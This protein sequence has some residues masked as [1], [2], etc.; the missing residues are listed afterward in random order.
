MDLSIINS[1]GTVLDKST[2]SDPSDI[3]GS[4]V[5]GNRYGWFA[6]NQFSNLAVDNSYQSRPRGCL[7]R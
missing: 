3:I 1:D 5:G 6:N 7:C 4:T 2:L